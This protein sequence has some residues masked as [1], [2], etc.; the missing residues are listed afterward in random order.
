[1][2]TDIEGVGT[3]VFS[4]ITAFGVLFNVYQ[5]IETKREV[6]RAARQAKDAAILASEHAA[7]AARGAQRAV[8][9]IGEVAV[10]VSKIEV[11]TN[12]MKDALV[13]STAAASHAEGK[14]EGVAEQKAEQEQKP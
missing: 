4:G 12:S 13:A 8:V 11:A 3:L 14:A 9:A 7:A 2:L 6:G 1:M 5:V 10:N